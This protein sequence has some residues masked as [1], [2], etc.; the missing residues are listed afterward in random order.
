MTRALRRIL[1]TAA[2]LDGRTQ[3][4]VTSIVGGSR[5]TF[6]RDV[7]FLRAVGCEIQW[8]DGAY[9]ITRPGPFDLQELR[10]VRL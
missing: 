5:A 6:R 3:P 4:R 10:K 8:R 1:R 2:V 7:D 9:L